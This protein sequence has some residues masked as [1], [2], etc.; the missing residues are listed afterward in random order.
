MIWKLF[1]L[2][3]SSI[4]L[5]VAILIIVLETINLDILAFSSFFVFLAVAM[6]IDFTKPLNEQNITPI[7]KSYF[8]AAICGLGVVFTAMFI[9]SI[10]T[11][12]T[13]INSKG[14]IQIITTLFKA[15]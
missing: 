5:C 10:Y 7:Q 3:I 8:K 9:S 12:E 14:F 2:F 1:K 6:W 4:C 13:H 11:S 15:L